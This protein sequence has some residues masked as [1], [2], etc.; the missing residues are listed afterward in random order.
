[1]NGRMVAGKPLYVAIAQTKEERKARLQ[2]IYNAT[3][4]RQLNICFITMLWSSLG[5]KFPKSHSG[6]IIYVCYAGSVFRI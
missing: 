5:I 1:M 6:N 2:V 3:T 4:G